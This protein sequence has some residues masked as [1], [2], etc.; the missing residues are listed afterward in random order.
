MTRRSAFTLIELLVV[1]AIIAILIG[2]L[3]P[4]VQKIREAASRI[5]CSNNLKQLG[6]AIHGYHD[7]NEKLPMGLQSI[8]TG[9][10]RDQMHAGPAITWNYYLLP[11]LEQDA[12]HR[13]I[14][15]VGT[16]VTVPAYELPWNINTPQSPM[17][18][19]LPVY[20]CPSDPGPLVYTQTNCYLA[21][22]NYL[23]LFGGVHRYDHEH[24]PVGA[25]TA[26]GWNYT[27][28]F[29]D[30]SDGLSGTVLLTEYLRGSNVQGDGRGIIWSGLAGAGS[31]MVALTPNS[32]TPDTLWWS[33]CSPEMNLP[34]ANLPCR[35]S[36]G[37]N[38]PGDSSDISSTARSRH[39]GGVQCVLGDGSV[40][41]VTNS[42]S[43]STWQAAATIAGGEV[44]GNDW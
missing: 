40:K 44:L 37:L 27:T 35:P 24:L 36:P 41:F 7:G 31:I 17:A 30:F 8:P 18:V 29:S 25:R 10:R 26:L 34:N 28:R 32:S 4:A 19:V 22:S 16:G 39:T 6:I 5:K 2:L 23:P 33:G 42:I 12:L 38:W 1:I 21:K 20:L 43:L 9:N 15:Y 14:T 3:L 11:F 13:Q